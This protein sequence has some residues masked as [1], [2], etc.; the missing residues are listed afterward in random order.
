MRRIILFP[1]QLRIFYTIGRQFSPP[2]WHPLARMW[3]TGFKFSQ[4]ILEKAGRLIRLDEVAGLQHTNQRSL[5]KLPR[6]VLQFVECLW[7]ELTREGHPKFAL[8]ATAGECI[9][10]ASRDMSTCGPAKA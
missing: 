5:K 2:L 9:A 10:L 8:A 6:R 3:L 7:S 1:S 4:E